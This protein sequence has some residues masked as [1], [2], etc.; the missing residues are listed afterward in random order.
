MTGCSRRATVPGI[1]FA[2][3]SEAPRRRRGLGQGR[4]ADRWLG[5]TRRIFGSASGTLSC[6][7]GVPGGDRLPFGPR[8]RRAGLLAVLPQSR[9]EP[10]PG[11]SR[12]SSFL[13][14]LSLCTRRASHRIQ[15]AER[16]RAWECVGS[17]LSGRLAAPSSQS[18]FR[19]PHAAARDRLQGEHS[20]FVST[21]QTNECSDVDEIRRQVH[22]EETNDPV[23]QRRFSLGSR[24]SPGPRSSEC[25]PDSSASP[26]GSVRS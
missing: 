12:T 10:D 18:S 6:Q 2:F 5:R 20:S 22:V 16:A 7:A 23:T 11:P 4:A 3:P 21:P 15:R 24:T 17:C 26:D 13:R 1:S 25:R 9:C 14:D 8:A 19:A